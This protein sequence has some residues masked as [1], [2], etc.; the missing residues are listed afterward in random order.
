MRSRRN[1]RSAK[2]VATPA[3]ARATV[4]RASEAARSRPRRDNPTLLSRPKAVADEADRMDER[5]SQPV[6]FLAQVRHEGL[7]NVVVPVEVVVPHMIEDL[8]LRE[9]PAGV[10]HEVAEEVE[11][12]GGEVDLGP[13]AAHLVGLLVED[14]VGE[15]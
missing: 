1:K 8:G 15:G 7:H 14:E 4:R 3:T 5:R 9:H 11:L 10:E 12:G 2:Y 13:V 6:Q